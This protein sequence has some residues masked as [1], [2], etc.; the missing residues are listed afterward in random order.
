T[1]VW[2]PLVQ[3]L[4]SKKLEKNVAFQDPCHLLHAQKIQSQPRELLRAMG[5]RVVDLPHAHQCCGSAGSYN[6]SQTELSMQILDRKM[7][8]LAEVASTIE[9]LVTANTG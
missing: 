9:M 2:G 1:E 3:R 4:P 6:V 7:D 8:D 5:A